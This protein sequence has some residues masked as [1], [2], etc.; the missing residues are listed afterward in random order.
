M[1]FMPEHAPLAVM[2][3]LGTAG[4]LALVALV[5][6]F[7]LWARKKWIGIGAGA[8]ALALLSGYLLI[9]LGVS[10]TS[11]EKLLALGERKYFCEIDCHIAYSVSGVKKPRCSE[12]SCIKLRQPAASS[13][14]T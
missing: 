7:A 6:L 8:V 12:M 4:L 10:Q 5:L 13:L 1:E 3:F 11:H 2:A 14:S 9:L